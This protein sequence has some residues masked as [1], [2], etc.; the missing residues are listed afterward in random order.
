MNIEGFDLNLLVVF[1]AL[2]T[3]RNVT[4]AA[5]RVG[6]SQPAFSNALSRLRARV[7]DPLF[8]RTRDGMVPTARA[9]AMADP[10]HKALTELDRALAMPRTQRLIERR[11]TM[12]ANGYAQC[13]LLPGVIR[14]LEKSAPGIRLELRSPRT[15]RAAA[16]LTLDW[17]ADDTADRRLSSVVVRDLLVCVA[18]RDNQS[19]KQRIE[20][21]R[22]GAASRSTPAIN[23][24]FVGALCLVAQSDEVAIVPRRLAEWFAPRLSL[25][26]FKPALNFPAVVLRLKWQ[27]HGASDPVVMSVKASILEVGTRLTSGSRP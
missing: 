15:V 21:A 6:L 24:E 20:L 23:R 25:Q 12:D 2:L 18:R 10:V 17:S 22:R 7:G 27:A 4:R 8:K 19:L 16:M 26:I 11:I 14:L 1:E 5:K 3:D 13:V 9:L